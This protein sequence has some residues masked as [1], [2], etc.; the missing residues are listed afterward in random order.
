MH[1]LRT[2]REVAIVAISPSLR[3]AKKR[4]GCFITEATQTMCLVNTYFQ[5]QKSNTSQPN[6]ELGGSK[7]TALLVKGRE[8]RPTEVQRGLLFI[9]L[10]V[11]CIT[12]TVLEVCGHRPGSNSR[13]ALLPTTAP[14][15]A[16][17]RH[18][19]R[20]AHPSLSRL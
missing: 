1:M 20:F 12:E 10:L 15:L 18:T 2:S 5:E 6:V 14:A 8:T 4:L 16:P 3:G 9:Y 17:L 11:M 19:R 13:L 7:R